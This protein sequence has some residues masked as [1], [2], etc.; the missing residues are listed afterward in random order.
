MTKWALGF[1]S[2]GDTY[3]ARFDDGKV[4]TLDAPT[5]GKPK[6]K[7]PVS[8]VPDLVKEPV[9]EVPDERI[10]FIDEELHDGDEIWCEM[11]GPAG[12]LLYRAYSKG[13][14]IFRVPVIDIPSVEDSADDGTEDSEE[15]GTF[16]SNRDKLRRDRTLAVMQLAQ[17]S[18]DKFY[19]MRVADAQVAALSVMTRNFD[20]WQRRIRIKAQTQLMQINRDLA[21]YP[22]QSSKALARMRRVFG[23]DDLLKET[24][25]VESQMERFIA[26]S[27]AD[28][29]LFNLVFEPINGCGVITSARIID[30]IQDIR[31]F[32]SNA[33][34][35]RYSGWFPNSPDGQIVRRR[36]GEL[37]R[38]S[39]R[40]KQAANLFG[41]QVGQYG[42]GEE[43]RDLYVTTKEHE[44]EKVKPAHAERRARRKAIGAFLDRIFREW[45]RYEVTAGTMDTLQVPL[46]DIPPGVAQS[47]AY[48][49]PNLGAQMQQRAA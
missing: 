22:D 26:S 7:I 44:K 24:A 17:E 21:F 10:A 32:P 15:E 18:P 47:L 27:L 48:W 5:K 41:M 39:T 16:E 9:V 31:R 43:F 14:R 23:E 20:N 25:A 37:M 12:P 4:F 1:A 3:I 45:W 42:R 2:V 38:Y 49:Y 36:R 29:D 30:V 28:L 11:G 33:K 35:R 40:L 8:Q 6:K 34:F 46:E 13:I 19:V